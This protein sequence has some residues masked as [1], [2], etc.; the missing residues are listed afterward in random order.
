M[1]AA[2]A[3]DAKAVRGVAEP[4]LEAFGMRQ[5]AILCL[6]V[7]AGFVRCQA[8][9]TPRYGRLRSCSPHGLGAWLLPMPSIPDEGL[10]MGNAC[11][12]FVTR[13]S[14]GKDVA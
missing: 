14:W 2:L 13:P 10:R 6:T 5:G 9:A 7:L 1:R 8:R 3:P 4:A 12:R 11:G